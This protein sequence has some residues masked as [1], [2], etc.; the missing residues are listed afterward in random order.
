VTWTKRI[1]VGTDITQASRRIRWAYI[2]GY[3][4]AGVFIFNA[5]VLFSVGSLEV[6]GLWSTGQAGFVVFEAS[7]VAILSFGLSRRNKV[8]AIGLFG[9]FLLSRVP[10]LILGFLPSA[11]ELDGLMRLV[12]MQILP[13][14]L[15]FQGLRGVL[16]FH[17]L[18]HRHYPN[19]VFNS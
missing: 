10:L 8:A 4:Y 16:T 3:L 9:Y 2:C 5:I 12:V 1:L 6:K 18:K 17:D 13:A 7:L 14:Y 15:F 19:D 11:N